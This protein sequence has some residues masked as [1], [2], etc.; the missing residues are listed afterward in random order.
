MTKILSRLQ[1]VKVVEEEIADI[2]Y[3]K[4]M[5][6]LDDAF[7]FILKKMFCYNLLYI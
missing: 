3:F 4:Q 2:I 1:Y 6:Y 5:K 7:V